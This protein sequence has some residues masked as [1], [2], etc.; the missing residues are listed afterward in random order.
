MEQFDEVVSRLNTDSVKWDA[1]SQTYHMDDLLPLWVADMDFLAPQGVTTA[2]ENYLQKGIF[3]YSIV[4][5]GLYRSVIDWEKRRHHV[6]LTED[7]ILFTSG[8]LA[9]LSL[10]I[11][12]FTAPG[13]A[14]LIH[15]PVYPPFGAIVEN[16]ERQ[17]IRSP[18]NKKADHFEMDFQ[19]MEEKIVSNKIKA[20]ILCNPH[21]PGGRVWT[22][23]E[24]KQLS[25]LCLTYD[26]FLFS[27]EIHQDVVFSGYEFTSM[28]T[29][30]PAL[31]RLLITFTSATKTFNLA[32]IKNSMVFIKDQ[33]LKNRFTKQLE[34]NQHQ[35]INTFGLLG[36][37]AAYE[38]GEEWLNE[39]LVYLEENVQEVI[40][41]FTKHLPAVKV[42]KPEG[43][44]LIWLDF[45]AYTD[46]DR[47]LEKKLIEKGRVV[48]NP[49]ISFGPSGHCHMRLNVAC[50]RSV[51]KEGLLRIQRALS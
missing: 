43:T 6:T 26:I 49:G 11:Q 3:G 40:T 16:N 17:L 31:S 30:D 23:E 14:V 2:L 22:K 38:T 25:E 1:I 7:N 48:L 42:M 4:P 27:D 35:G 41:F 39:L 33:D 50:P 21:N 51:L 8:V 10:A 44:Y 36:T 28:Q 45:S 9:S 13:D 24:L 37:Q 19:D 47:L 5:N 32:A 34:K 18:L 12:A 15:D 46:D 20:M 29:I